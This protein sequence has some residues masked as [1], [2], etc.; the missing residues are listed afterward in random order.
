MLW[1]LKAKCHEEE[2]DFRSVLMEEVVLTIEQWNLCLQINTELIIA[3]LQVVSVRVLIPWVQS[4]S[5][6]S[7]VLSRE[8]G[9]PVDEP[10]ASHP[11]LC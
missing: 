8:D 10:A 11:E 2:L 6:I 9:M 7:F 1:A 3:Y 5:G 4:D